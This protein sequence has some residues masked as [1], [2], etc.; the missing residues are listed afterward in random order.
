MSDEKSAELPSNS[1]LTVLQ[2]KELQESLLTEGSKLLAELAL[3]VKATKKKGTL[4]LVLTLEP[5]KGGAI[6]VAAALNLKAPS[7]APQHLTIFFIDKE[8]ALV[9]DNPEQK[10]LVLT[11]HDGGAKVKEEEQLQNG[12]ARAQ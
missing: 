3:A 10:E 1:F 11:P 9:R 2:R 5:E 12:E 7:T 4:S 6:S 8:G